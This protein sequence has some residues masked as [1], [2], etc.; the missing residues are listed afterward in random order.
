MS[1]KENEPRFVDDS[2][3]N[4]LFRQLGEVAPFT[5]GLTPGWRGREAWAWGDSFLLAWL[6][7]HGMQKLDAMAFAIHS[8]PLTGGLND[9]WNIVSDT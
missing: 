9:T 8:N 3:S 4:S 5:V 1:S 2:T 7:V 6:V